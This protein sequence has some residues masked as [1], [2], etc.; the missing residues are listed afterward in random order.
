M[1][2]GRGLTW[3]PSTLF[4][5]NVIFSGRS[6]QL[7]RGLF[8]FSPGILSSVNY[9]EEPDKEE[10]EGE[11]LSSPLA[12][13]EETAA[14]SQKASSVCCA[15]AASGTVP[16]HLGVFTSGLLVLFDPSGRPLPED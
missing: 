15:E 6:W 1:G 11:T 16:R 3:G 8:P 10:E 5:T 12:R 9:D 4:I 13:S 2:P 14:A 7:L